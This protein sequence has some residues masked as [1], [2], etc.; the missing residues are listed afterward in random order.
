MDIHFDEKKGLF[1]GLFWVGAIG[2]IMD[3]EISIT[4]MYYHLSMYQRLLFSGILAFRDGNAT[5]RIC[6]FGNCIH[7]L[8]SFVSYS[9]FISQWFLGSSLV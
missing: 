7:Y 1:P 2:F 9:P 3:E 5:C 6:V 4:E 8:Y